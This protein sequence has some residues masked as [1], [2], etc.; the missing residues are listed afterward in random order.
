MLLNEKLCDICVNLI[1]LKTTISDIFFDL[2][3]TLW[4][5][6]KNSALA[7]GV[8]FKENDIRIDLETFLSFYIPINIKYWELYRK[9]QI[10]QQDLRISRL[11]ESFQLMDFHINDE[12]LH[13]LSEQYI[14]YLPK[15]NHLFDGAIPILDYLQPKYN[16]HI[17]T[18]G[19]HTVQYLKLLNSNIL[20][21]FK[22]V[23]NSESV[24]VKKPNPIIYE[25]AIKT[26]QTKKEN[27]LMI[28]DCVE[29]DVLGALNCGIDAI[30][31]N[32]SK[33]DVA[34]NVKQINHLLDLKK[35]L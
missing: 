3:H 14:E 27:S 11:K 20:H 28:G 1:D 17:I 7:F 34:Y 33:C 22:T 16:L 18:N 23:T 10:T 31:F 15:F 29:A 8:L 5:F 30:L 13:L 26:A 9:D 12:K 19:F 21:Y 32:E 35:Y 24:G 2:D 25:Y 6:E 4:D